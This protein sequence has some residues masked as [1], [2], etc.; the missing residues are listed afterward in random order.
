MLESRF[1]SEA[2]EDLDHL[3]RFDDYIVGLS[4]KKI[5]MMPRDYVLLHGSGFE[6]RFHKAHDGHSGCEL[7][8][9]QGVPK[10]DRVLWCLRQTITASSKMHASSSLGVDGLGHSLLRRKIGIWL[11]WRILSC[12]L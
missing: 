8:R 3:L 12:R 2:P 11:C 4:S 7:D 1:R 5:F 9:R 10:L 6:G